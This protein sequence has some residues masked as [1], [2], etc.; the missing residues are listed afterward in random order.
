MSGSEHREADFALAKDFV[1]EQCPN[2]ICEL[3]AE[4]IPEGEIDDDNP[5]LA[6]HPE[7]IQPTLC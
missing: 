3:S 2:R 6:H 5:S 1:D 7:D 4:P